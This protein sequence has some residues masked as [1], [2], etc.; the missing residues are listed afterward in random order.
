[1]GRASVQPV[2]TFLLARHGETDWNRQ[3]RFQGTADPPLNHEGRE[4]AR[5][6]AATIAETELAEILSSDLHC[7]F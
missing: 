7:A 3:R 2:T 4:Q 1:M 6:L 5:R